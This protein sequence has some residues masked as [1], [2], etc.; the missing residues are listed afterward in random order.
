MIAVWLY[1]WLHID[2][3]V[4]TLFKKKRK[5]SKKNIKKRTINNNKNPITE[6]RGKKNAPCTG[7]FFWIKKRGLAPNL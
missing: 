3:K 2:V 7:D 4:V 5:R 1:A 6:V